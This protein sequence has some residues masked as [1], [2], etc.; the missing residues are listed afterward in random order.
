MDGLVDR[1]LIQTPFASDP[2]CVLG[3]AILFGLGDFGE[4]LFEE[5]TV[6]LGEL[7]DAVK[8]LAHGLTHVETS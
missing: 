6:L 8:D 4:P 2:A 1:R 7:F 3:L 5:Q